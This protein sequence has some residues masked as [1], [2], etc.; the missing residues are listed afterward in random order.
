[1]VIVF[2]YLVIIVKRLS[3]SA[4][5]LFSASFVLIAFLSLTA[6]SLNNAFQNSADRAQKKQLKNTIY[7]LLSAADFS[8][9]GHILMPPVSAIPEL[10]LPQSGLYA[11]I[12]KDDTTVWQSE[13]LLD[14]ELDL[15]YNLG[16][17]RESF[18]LYSDKQG[19][20]YINLSYKII[21]ENDEEQQFTFTFNVSENLAASEQEK[22]G[23]RQTLWSLLGGTALLL[24][25]AQLLV[26]RW[27]LKPLSTAAADLQA[28]EDGQQNR[29]SGNYPKELNQLTKNINTLLDQEQARRSR[30]KNALADLAHSIKTPLALIRGEITNKTEGAASQ[31]QV[32]RISSLVDYQLQRAATEGQSTLQAP[33]LLNDIIQKLM[34][35]L[36]KVYQDKHIDSN[37]SDPEPVLLHSDEGDLYELIG[38]LLENA[39]KYCDHQVSVLVERYPNRV[40]II[41]ED[42]GVGIPDTEKQNILKRGQRIDSHAEGQGIGLAIV[43]DIISAYQGELSISQSRLGGAQF[44]VSLP[45]R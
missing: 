42:D 40:N 21:W 5:L 19:T 13:S 33:V 7:S 36:D 11:T 16:D 37:Y 28:I 29:L 6:L 26:L 9:A 4:R 32:D 27:S 24:L 43:K 44:T 25:I 12:V 38:N 31:D 1:M 3:L 45:R 15:P 39:Y 23:F 2:H 22:A 41:I 8:E 30:Y 20:E 14:Q 18:T 35:S 17:A 10:T 34:T